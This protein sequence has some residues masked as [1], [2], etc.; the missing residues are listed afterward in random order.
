MSSK[1]KS[2][3]VLFGYIACTIPKPGK[4]KGSL[5]NTEHKEQTDNS[6]AGLGVNTQHV[7]SK[8][9]NALLLQEVY[10]TSHYPLKM[11]RN[12]PVMGQYREVTGR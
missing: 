10:R 1:S 3:C 4:P 12:I 8:N 6:S 2:V 7:L 5:I 9:R 11:S